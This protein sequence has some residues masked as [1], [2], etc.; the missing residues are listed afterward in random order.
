MDN[1]V[2]FGEDTGF[3]KDM[4]KEDFNILGI[5]ICFKKNVLIWNYILT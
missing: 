5:L 3:G 1:V 2:T 4:V